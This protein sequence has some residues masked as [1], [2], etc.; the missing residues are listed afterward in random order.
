MYLNN[1]KNRISGKQKYIGTKK[2]HQSI[3]KLDQIPCI[4]L[5]DHQRTSMV[6]VLP[7]KVRHKTRGAVEKTMSVSHWCQKTTIDSTP[8]EASEASNFGNPRI[9]GRLPSWSF[10]TNVNLENLKHK[11][12]PWDS[13]RQQIAWHW[14]KHVPDEDIKG[15]N[16]NMLNKYSLKQIAVQKSSQ[17]R[18]FIQDTVFPKL[19]K[20]KDMRWS[21]VIAISIALHTWIYMIHPLPR[22]NGWS[23]NMFVEGKH[24]QGNNRWGSMM[25]SIS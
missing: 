7:G 25:V 13:Q 22:T 23:L 12:P 10:P 1:V 11:L 19:V 15:T 9:N 14:K 6:M 24:L 21:L 5:R 20:E 3:D 17:S 4:P 16:N 8:I 18:V 2:M